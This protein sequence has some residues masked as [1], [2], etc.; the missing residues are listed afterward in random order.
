M[1]LSRRASGHGIQTV[2]LCD[3]AKFSEC[4]SHVCTGHILVW[5]A[6][7]DIDQDGVAED[8]KRYLAPRFF[9]SDGAMNGFFRME[10]A[11]CRELSEEEVL[12]TVS[13][14]L[15]WPA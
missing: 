2:K 3:D 4:Y 1:R 10:S 13:K 14:K 6:D 12:E 8:E 15:V 7:L 11:D 5:H 9:P